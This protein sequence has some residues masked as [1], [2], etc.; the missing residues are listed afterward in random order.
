MRRRRPLHRL[1]TAFAVTASL[2]F[3]Q[4]ALANYV[5]PGPTGTM[6]MVDASASGAP[7]EGMDEAQ[8]LLCHQLAASA[9]Q[10]VDVLKVVVPTIPI[11]VQVLVVPRLAD[12]TAAALP[13]GRALAAARSPPEP[14]FLSTLRL[15]V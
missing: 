4:L 2:L 12:A 8:P 9:P 15:R 13:T 10:S 7:C 11:I 3:S 14:L 6:S 5:C 1:L